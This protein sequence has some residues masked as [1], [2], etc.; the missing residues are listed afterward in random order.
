M[1]FLI[2]RA[3]EREPPC[4]G[5]VRVDGVSEFSFPNHYW[6]VNVNSLEETLRLAELDGD[7][8]IL[9]RTWDYEK[10]ETGIEWGI[11]IYDS[12]IE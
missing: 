6:T 2:K 10:R 7:G 4:D 12:Y 3:S 5:A 8:I 1:T 9:A 11:M